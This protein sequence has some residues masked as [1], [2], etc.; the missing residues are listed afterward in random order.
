MA[1]IYF[2][3][4]FL[5]TSVEYTEASEWQQIELPEKKKAKNG[6]LM[7]V[8][9]PTKISF[10]TVCGSGSVSFFTIVF[11]IKYCG[12]ACLSVYLSVCP[13]ACLFVC[14]PICRSICLPACLC[15]SVWPIIMN[16]THFQ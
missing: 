2:L 1:F 16:L 13:P 14:L 5:L 3:P 6:V 10:Y 9:L 7:Y 8:L 15:M 4:G 11:Y 12:L